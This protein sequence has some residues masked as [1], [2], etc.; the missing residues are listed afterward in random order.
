MVVLIWLILLLLIGCSVFPGL[1]AFPLYIVFI[2][3][4]GV[5]IGFYKK[6]FLN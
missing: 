5:L 6:D 3:V 2:I 4:A 1:W